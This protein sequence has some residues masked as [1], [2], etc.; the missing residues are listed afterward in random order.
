MHEGIGLATSTDGLH[1]ERYAN[2]PIVQPDLCD[3]WYGLSV[4][5]LHGD[6]KRHSRV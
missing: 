1:W 5:Y 2:K 4:Q 3:P 6:G